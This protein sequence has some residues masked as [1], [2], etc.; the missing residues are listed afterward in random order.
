MTCQK[1]ILVKQ[2]I[3]AMKKGDAIM[4]PKGDRMLLEFNIPS[5]GIIGLRNY[6]LTVTAEAIM[7]HRFIEF[8]PYKG[9]IPQRQNGSLSM[10]KGNQY[11]LV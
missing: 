9:D 1:A 11:L 3:V 5:R 4:V 8:Q 2:L 10:E 6:L 7:S